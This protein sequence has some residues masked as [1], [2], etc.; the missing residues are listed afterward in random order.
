M[1]LSHQE[2]GL[3]HDR[4]TTTEGWCALREDLAGA[5]VIRVALDSNATRGPVSSRMPADSLAEAFQ[6]LPVRGQIA[7]L[8][9]NRPTLRPAS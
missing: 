6:V 5:V 4:L 1:H 8:L 3:R 7:R 9:L 2:T